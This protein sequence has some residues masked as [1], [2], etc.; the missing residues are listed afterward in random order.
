M[1]VGRVRADQFVEGVAWLAKHR[2]AADGETLP[3]PGARRRLADRASECKRPTH[4]PLGTAS[5]GVWACG[6]V[7]PQSR[8]RGCQM[9]RRP[10]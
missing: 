3:N 9:S 7:V 5:V 10:G 6:R 4:A 1:H 8:P 2:Y